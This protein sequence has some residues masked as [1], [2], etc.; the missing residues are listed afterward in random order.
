MADEMTTTDLLTRELHEGQMCEIKAC[1]VVK[2]SRRYWGRIGRESCLT[3]EE[4]RDIAQVH[5]SWPDL[6]QGWAKVRFEL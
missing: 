3:W 5:V 6:I 4:A 2:N 1:W